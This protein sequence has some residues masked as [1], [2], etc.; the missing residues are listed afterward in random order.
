MKINPLLV[1]AAVL[2]AIAGLALLFASGEILSMAG[3]RPSLHVTWI[4]QMLAGALLGLFGRR[5]VP[6]AVLG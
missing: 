6:V 1:A 4:A 2:Y 3:T 5:V